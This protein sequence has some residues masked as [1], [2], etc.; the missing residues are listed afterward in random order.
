MVSF[1]FYKTEL[2]AVN[3]VACNIY[4]F[5]KEKHGLT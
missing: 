2:K 3:Y 5:I 1:S 4:M